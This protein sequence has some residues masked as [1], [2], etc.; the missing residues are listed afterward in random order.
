VNKRIFIIYEMIFKYEQ[1]TFSTEI[2]GVQRYLY[3][4]SIIL[5][6]AGYDVYVLQF[7]NE[8]IQGEISSIKID[9][10]I[11]EKKQYLKGF[12]YIK[13]KYCI[14]QSDI[15]IWGADT[16]SEKIDHN[17]ILSIQH[18]IAFDMYSEDS[19]FKMIL[20]KC[21]LIPIYKFYQRYI[22]LKKS[23][24][25]NY[26]VCV[27]YNYLNWLRTYTIKHNN[28]MNNIHVIPNFTKILSFDKKY[29]SRLKICF[30]RRFVHK[31]GVD[32]MLNVACMILNKRN[33]VDFY[34][35]GDGK[36]KIKILALQQ[37]Y[38]KNIFITKFNQDQTYNF[39]SK[40]DI[41]VVP[42]LGS[43]GTSLSLLEAMSCKCAVVT[44]NIGG[45]TNIVIDDFNGKIVNPTIE[46]IYLS[47]MEL[48]ESPV[49]RK[50]LSENAYNTV[51][52]G[53]NYNL[54]EKKWIDMIKQVEN[55]E[56]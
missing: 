52:S 44:T 51:K 54:W 8:K 35:A 39:H 26:M 49:K 55:Y 40:M 6:K 50:F 15:I 28:E 37:K 56:K 19:K 42:T 18:G 22:A 41:A 38:P 53:F 48:I 33:D 9:Q 20:K 25:S 23:Q 17:K 5:S 16:I 45:L 7:G 30:A 10:L 24:N 47:I 21:N 34:F 2:G 31:R 27:D 43:E 1:G 36:E 29:N 12:N 13:K 46:N 11:V 14:G 3:E 32:T 4:L